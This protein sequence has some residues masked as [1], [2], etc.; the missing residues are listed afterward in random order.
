MR[1]DVR[2][3]H[4]AL[5]LPVLLISSLFPAPAAAATV[6][7]GGDPIFASSGRCSLGFNAHNATT[8]YLVT[9]GHCV[10]PA[11]TTVYADAGRTVV[12]GTTV[13]VTVPAGDYAIVRYTNS[14]VGHPSSVNLYPG[15]QSITA[16]GT[17]YVGQSVRRSG[18]TTGVRSGTVT[19]VNAT[20]NFPGGTLTGLI[21][22]NICA[23][24]GDN[25]GPLFS[26]GTALGILVGGSGNCTT[27]GTS[28]YRPIREVLAAYGLT[29]P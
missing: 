7:S 1:T 27:G 11:G 9:A 5:L 18:A 10:S 22:T 19:G 28:Y 25:G 29:I 16:A 26:G 17:P 23:E 3:L 2:P 6:K 4:L 14:A 21:R 12:L 8:W 13:G 15:S 20:V 24:P